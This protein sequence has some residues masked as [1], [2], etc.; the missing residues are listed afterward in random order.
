MYI[1]SG[2]CHALFLCPCDVPQIV[3]R[4][5]A[6]KSV[7]VREVPSGDLEVKLADLGVS[8]HLMDDKAYLEA[9]AVSSYLSPCR[10]VSTAELW[11][12]DVIIIF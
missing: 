12:G 6:A 7:L 8:H 5:L 2:Q 10:F 9:C 1:C 4:H 11:H 3:H